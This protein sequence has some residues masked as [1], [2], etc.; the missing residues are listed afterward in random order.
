M[1]I[2][3]TSGNDKLFGTN[4]DDVI[5]GGDGNDALDGGAGND[6]LYGSTGDDLYI[7]SDRFDSVYDSGGSD[8]GIIHV[9]FYKTDPTVENWSWAAGVQRLPYWIDALLPGEAPG[10]V[11]LLG[12]SKTY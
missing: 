7:I 10:F 5:F 8:S 9:D 2:N 12:G 1:N 11:P 3:G 6:Q 4:A